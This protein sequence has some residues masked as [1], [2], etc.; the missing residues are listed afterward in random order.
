MG[1]A[2]KVCPICAEVIQESARKCRFCGEWLDADPREPTSVQS[3]PVLE[4]PWGGAGPISTA[5]KS[6]GSAP[7]SSQSAIP[8]G[9]EPQPS[10]A[11]FS[12]RPPVNGLAVASLVLGLVGA[13]VGHLLALILGYRA[14]KQIRDSNGQQ[15]GRAAAIAGITLGWIGTVALTVLLIALAVSAIPTPAERAHEE[16]RQTAANLAFAEK[17]YKE[18]NGSYTTDLTALSPLMPSPPPDVTLRVYY[19]NAESFCVGA[20]LDTSG[21]D[22]LRAYG[23]AIVSSDGFNEEGTSV[24]VTDFSRGGGRSCRPV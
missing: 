5:Q 1:T 21:Y 11:A 8:A 6:A 23:G 22:N 10:Q 18:E 17:Q 13:G 4:W 3:A 20:A 2:T 16:T 19:A 14:K 24:R 12:R 9:P 15:S 7:P